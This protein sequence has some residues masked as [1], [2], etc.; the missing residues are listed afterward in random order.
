MLVKVRRYLIEMANDVMDTIMK[1]EKY[2]SE[3]GL[4]PLREIDRA[5]YNA[6][7]GFA[8]NIETIREI[9]AAYDEYITATIQIKEEN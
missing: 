3:T 5:I 8:T 1:D 4:E 9:L 2:T 6:Q 7:A